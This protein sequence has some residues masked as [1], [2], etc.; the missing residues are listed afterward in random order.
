MN[1]HRSWLAG[2]IVLSCACSK[3]QPVQPSATENATPRA[4]MAEPSTA[5][6]I[7]RARE[8]APTAEP[9]APGAQESDSPAAEVER[10][11][12]DPSQAEQQG[13][14]KAA[15]AGA[16][17]GAERPLAPSPTAKQQS[18]ESL[19]APFRAR[20]GRRLAGHAV[21]QSADGET[22][23]TVD[24]R[25]APAEL[26][27]IRLFRVESCAPF[28]VGAGSFSS[29]ARGAPRDL[30]KLGELRLSDGKG[31]DAYELPR[32]AGQR[33]GAKRA[34]VAF[35]PVEAHRSEVSEP[36]ACAELP[37]N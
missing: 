5:T 17:A 7:A 21:F 22:T 12:G 34:I 16:E 19:R 24:V 28:G 8:P 3:S 15:G 23:L 9:S 10:S 2:L 30:D 32:V 1:V 27:R 29:Q 25:D 20:P 14:A 11:R 31:T 26:D 33:D 13:S 4:G 35:A 37:R 18:D 6:P 36:I